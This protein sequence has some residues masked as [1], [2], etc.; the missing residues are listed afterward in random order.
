MCSKVHYITSLRGTTRHFRRHAP[1]DLPTYCTNPAPKNG[2]TPAPSH[3]TQPS[4]RSL[5]D[6]NH[7]K[8]EPTSQNHGPKASTEERS[9]TQEQQ[10][11]TCNHSA[12][13]STNLQGSLLERY[14]HPRAD[15]PISYSRAPASARDGPMAPALAAV[16]LAAL[17]HAGRHDAEAEGTMLAL[18]VAIGRVETTLACAVVAPP[19]REV[20]VGGPR[21][22][23]IPFV[24]MLFGE[25]Q[26]GDRESLRRWLRYVGDLSESLLV[27]LAG[28]GERETVGRGGGGGGADVEVVKSR[29]SRGPRA[30]SGIPGAWR[31][32]RAI[33]SRKKGLGLD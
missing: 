18:G 7:T 12:T 14:T 33:A 19:D 3:T 26:R 5:P 2:S 31:E 21:C 8:A 1:V 10:G 29:G 16:R 15:F 27:E 13:M 24:E 25:A 11:Q 30:G 23:K 9:A 28:E 6:I 32:P 20:R 4:E 22:S 17:Q